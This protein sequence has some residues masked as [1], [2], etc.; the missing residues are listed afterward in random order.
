MV[1]RRGVAQIGKAAQ[2]CRGNIIHAVESDVLQRIDD[3]GLARAGKTCHNQQAPWGLLRG[4]F[5]IFHY[6]YTGCGRRL[7][8]GSGWIF[9]A[10]M[11]ILP[12]ASHTFLNRI[13]RRKSV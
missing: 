2:Q 8:Y 9:P 13:K 3:A 1:G 5:V 11:I 12:G 4:W 6:D 7:Q 10:A